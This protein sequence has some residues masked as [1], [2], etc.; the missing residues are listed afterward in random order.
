MLFKLENFENNT[1]IATYHCQTH[2]PIWD[3][4][5]LAIRHYII[6]HHFTRLYVKILG[7]YSEKSDIL[8]KKS[9][10]NKHCRF[11]AVIRI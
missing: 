5:N 2:S 3:K 11:A 8:K 4:N 1:S 10:G 6:L 7:I 9:N